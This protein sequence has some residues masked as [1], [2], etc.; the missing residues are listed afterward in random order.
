MIVNRSEIVGRP[1]A[2][3]LANDGAK[4]ISADDK[5]LQEFYRGQG[6]RKRQ[7]EVVDSK[8][9]TLE[10][11]AQ[12]ADVVVCGVPSPK[13]KFQTSWLRDGAIAINFSSEKNFQDDIKERASIYVPSIGK[14]TIAML[15]RNLWVSLLLRSQSNC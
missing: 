4:V 5:G 14:V 9:D 13:F 15:Q 3:L 2:A 11:A 12:M 6:I 8:I 7:H 1:L 10:Q